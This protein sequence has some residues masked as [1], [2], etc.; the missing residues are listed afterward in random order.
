MLSIPCIFTGPFFPGMSLDTGLPK[1]NYFN[2]KDGRTIVNSS[3][4]PL[5]SSMT[6]AVEESKA[7]QQHEARKQAAKEKP[8]TN[9]SKVGR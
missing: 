1:P 2:F 3:A 9:A 4:A 5:K 6:K 7:R 8:K